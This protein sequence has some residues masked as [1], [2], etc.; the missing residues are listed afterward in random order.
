MY[1]KAVTEYLRCHARFNA[2]HLA[3]VLEDLPYSLSG[4]RLAP[5]VHEYEV[6]N[7]MLPSSDDIVRFFNVFFHSSRSIAAKRNYPAFVIDVSECNEIH[8]QIDVAES[9]SDYLR[10]S[11]TGTVHKLQQSLVAKALRIISRQIHQFCCFFDRKIIYLALVGLYSLDPRER[12]LADHAFGD[13]VLVIHSERRH[14]AVYSR[15]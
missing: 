6:V 3:V 12:I 2:Q 1:R 15:F 11:C 7:I 8:P 13:Q 10:D 9:Q 14:F 4:K 5:E